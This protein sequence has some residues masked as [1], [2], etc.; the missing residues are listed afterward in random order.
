MPVAGELGVGRPT[1]RGVGRSVGTPSKA[2]VRVHL[3][4]RYTAGTKPAFYMYGVRMGTAPIA[5]RE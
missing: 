1:M 3:A 5:N 2:G 4:L